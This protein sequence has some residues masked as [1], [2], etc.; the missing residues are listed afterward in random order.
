[1]SLFRKQAGFT[2]VEI[3]VVAPLM[4][5][6]II[7]MMTYL[8]NQFGQLTQEG[9]RLRL[10]TD[11]QLITLSIQDD[12]YFASAFGSAKNSNLVDNYAP[13][14]GWVHNTNPET[15]IIST[16]AL[17]SSNRDADRKPVYINTVGCDESVVED[18]S[19]LQNNII[20]FVSGGKLYK[21]I[22]SAPVGMATCGT[23]FQKQTCP[24]A[25]A[26]QTCQKDILLSDKLHQFNVTYYDEENDEVSTPEQ[27]HL[28]KIEVTLKDRAFAE[29]VYGSSNI[30]LK[31][32]N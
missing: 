10:T 26:T 17:T 28:V 30:T 24:E 21:R 15:L 6:T 14:G 8:F 12:I 4:M 3:L 16:A 25:N 2:L 20:L 18:N 1:M 19:V 5:V 11:A 7:V 31:R 32:L 13:S 27:A 23:S 29:D 9:S 22:L